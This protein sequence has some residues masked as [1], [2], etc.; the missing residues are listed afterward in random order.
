MI[1]DTQ[2]NSVYMAEVDSNLITSK[3]QSIQDI[4]NYV[5]R[6]RYSDHNWNEFKKFG[7]IVEESKD[8]YVSRGSWGTIFIA[9]F[10]FNK[11]MVLHE[12]SHSIDY[13]DNGWLKDEPHGKNWCEIYL[14]IIYKFLGE[15]NYQIMKKSFDKYNIK[16]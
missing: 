11:L 14:E 9:P 7:V 3:F 2:R 8:K 13:M 6:I 5:N 10:S 4:Q 12:L 1:K 16:Y 15:K